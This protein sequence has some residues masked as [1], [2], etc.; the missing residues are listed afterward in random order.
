MSLARFPGSGNGG[1]GGYPAAQTIQAEDYTAMSGLSVATSMPN[2]TGTGHLSSWVA[3]DWASFAV[4]C[5]RGVNTITTRCNTGSSWYWEV[6]L[7]SNTGTLIGRLPFPPDT[8]WGSWVSWTGAVIPVR[9]VQT[10]VLVAGTPFADWQSPNLDYLTL[11]WT[12]SR[13]A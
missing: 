2:Y 8:G 3:G 11:S 7:G 4:N 5:G 1:D 9:G 10:L 6:R 12:D 13:G